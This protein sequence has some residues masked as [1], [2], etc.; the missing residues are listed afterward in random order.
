MVSGANIDARDSAE[1]TI[2]IADA[3]L[4]FITLAI[5]QRHARPQISKLANNRLAR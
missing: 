1:H 2:C 5:Q 4:Y 3:E